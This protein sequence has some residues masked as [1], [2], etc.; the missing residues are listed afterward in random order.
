M[1]Q[2]P[3][4][5]PL[6]TV[7]FVVLKG[8]LVLSAVAVKPTDYWGRGAAQTL[9]PCSLYCKSFPASVD[10]ELY[11]A[12]HLSIWYTVWPLASQQNTL[13]LQL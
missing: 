11:L 9:W 5:P 2:P 10:L 1:I 6:H 12:R 3:H 7:E 8:E 4:H 13:P